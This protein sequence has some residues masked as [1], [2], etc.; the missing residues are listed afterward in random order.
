MPDRCCPS[1]RPVYSDPLQ[2]PYD[3]GWKNI[4]ECASIEVFEIMAGVRLSAHPAS[5][6]EPSRE[7]TAMVGL[8][9]RFVGGQP[10]AAP[11]LQRP[12][13]HQGCWEK[14]RSRIFP[15]LPTPSGSFAIW[16]PA[17]SRQRF[18]HWPTIRC[19][20]FRPVITGEDYAKQ[21]PEPPVGCLFALSYDSEPIWI[22]LIMHT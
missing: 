8:A 4:L 22:C 7:Q 6:E 2:V 13:L 18:S 16:W 19:F 5:D 20:P 11:A 1:L 3:T 14:K 21:T 10:C 15:W 12:S 17:T 9:G